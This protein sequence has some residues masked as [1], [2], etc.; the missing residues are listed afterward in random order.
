MSVG[1]AR[2]AGGTA[3]LV[4]DAARLVGGIARPAGGVTRLVGGVTRLVGGVTRLVGGVGDAAAAGATF[5][6][7]T[8]GGVCADF[9]AEGG[10]EGGSS[11][12]RV[13]LVALLGLA[14]VTGLAG[15]IGLASVA[16]L[17]CEV[18]GRKVVSAGFADAPGD[19]FCVG[20][21]ELS[22]DG[23]P[24]TP[25]VAPAP[26]PPPPP[27]AAPATSSPSVEA[28]AEAAGGFWVVSRA[29]G[30]LGAPVALPVALPAAR[31]VAVPVRTGSR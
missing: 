18:A 14:G 26:P 16:G 19:R 1:A 4:D 22:A 13:V 28:L 6:D 9:A 15:V 5:G 20:V 3:R 29:G 17:A 31:P 11:S 30:S 27:P 2:P 21:S 7:A 25:D 10:D 23:C 12:V 24:S 8:G